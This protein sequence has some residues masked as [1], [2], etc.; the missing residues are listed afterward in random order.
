M[1]QPHTA[2]GEQ[3]RELAGYVRLLTALVQPSPKRECLDRR[4]LA[5][6]LKSLASKLDQVAGEAEL[7]RECTLKAYQ[8][9][10]P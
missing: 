6:A 7:C 2:P 8:G 3:I 9:S 10:R 1:D 5:R 4:E